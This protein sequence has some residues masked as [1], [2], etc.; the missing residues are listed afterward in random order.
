MELCQKRLKLCSFIKSKPWT[1]NNLFDVLKIL[2]NNKT[3][4][5]HGLINELF[6]PENIGH[7]LF[8]SLLL[9]FNQ[10]K[11]ELTFPEFMKYANIHTVYKGWGDKMNLDFE[12][13]IFI[14][15]VFRSII[16]KMIY[17][18]QCNVIES[19]IS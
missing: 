14:V 5:P 1:E 16:M 15:N 8:Q 4:D 3:R 6:K 10:V 17:N 18:D 9:L 19:N 13:G 11:V 7:D 2:K 12:R